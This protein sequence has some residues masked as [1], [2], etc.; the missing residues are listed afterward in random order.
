MGERFKIDIFAYLLR[1]SYYIHRN[2]WRAG[3]VGRVADYK[4]SSYKAYAYGKSHQ[5]WL[6]TEAIKQEYQS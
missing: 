4:W 1:L 6:N 5:S 2:P 3:M